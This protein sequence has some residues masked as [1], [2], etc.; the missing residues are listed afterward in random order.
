MV[1]RLRRWSSCSQLSDCVTQ[2]FAV[3]PSYTTNLHVEN[4]VH[5]CQVTNSLLDI[6]HQCKL[7]TSVTLASVASYL[8]AS[9]FSLQHR[10]EPP[11]AHSST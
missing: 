9:D 5:I 10:K 6:P 4:K 11:T 7:L 3:V 2:A 1:G 8:Q